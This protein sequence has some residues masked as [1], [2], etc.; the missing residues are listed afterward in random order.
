MMNAPLTDQERQTVLEAR[1]AAL[2]VYR[3]IANGTQLPSPQEVYQAARAATEAKWAHQEQ[4]GDD[5]TYTVLEGAAMA[6]EIAAMIAEGRADPFS[7]DPR[8]HAQRIVD[9]IARNLHAD[10]A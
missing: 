8:Q 5:H 6:A 1:Q 7:G 2:E 9:S 10:L 4:H 3:A